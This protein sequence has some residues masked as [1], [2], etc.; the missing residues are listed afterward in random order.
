MIAGHVFVSRSEDVMAAR[1]LVEWDASMARVR[2]RMT[3]AVPERGGFGFDV[4]LVTKDDA[5]KGE[6]K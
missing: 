4:A 3:D 5:R 6:P 2:I 1:R